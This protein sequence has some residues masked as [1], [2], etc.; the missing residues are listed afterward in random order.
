MV[1]GPEAIGT[2]G[3]ESNIA[4]FIGRVTSV[5]PGNENMGHTSG[6]L[7]VERVFKGNVP[8]REM[9]VVGGGGGDCTISIQPGQHMITAA[10]V[11]GRTI[12]PGL[13]MP[14]GDPGT[15][16]GQVLVAA[17]VAA[18]GPGR[19]APEGPLVG[20]DPPTTTPSS[21]S[22]TLALSLVLAFAIGVALAL[23]GLVTVLTRRGRRDA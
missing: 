12:T 23:F 8:A 3:D 10:S 6:T 17:A 13:C 20:T 7:V 22:S 9:S 15:A 5:R 11:E 21:D 19:T 14:Y 18:Y 4:V 1:T 16:E 2:F